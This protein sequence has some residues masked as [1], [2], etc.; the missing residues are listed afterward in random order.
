MQRLGFLKLLVAISARHST[1]TLPTIGQE[2]IR[3]LTSKVDLR[4]DHQLAKYV[5]SALSEQTNANLRRL[6]AEFLKGD[7]ERSARVT[8]EIQDAYLGLGELRS[9][10]G[11]LAPT[12]D[13][14]FPHWGVSLGLTRK[15]PF[16][17]LVRG[18]LLLSLVPASE[19][20][21]FD[22]YDPCC[23]PLELTRSQRLFFLFVIFERDL[24]VLVPLFERL[25]ERKGQFSDLEAGD[26]LPDVYLSAS[27]SLRR[28]GRGGVDADRALQL[29]ETAAAIRARHGKSYGKTVRE[30]TVTPRLEP[31]VDLGLLS[32]R[33]AF[34]YSYE[35]T[36]E[37]RDFFANMRDGWGD[38]FSG[39][40]KSAAALLG[41]DDQEVSSD[42]AL[43]HFLHSAWAELKSNLGYSP[44]SETL[45]LGLI[46]SLEQGAGW[47]EL[48]RARD[49]LLRTRREVRGLLRFNMDRRGTLSV[50]RF[51]RAP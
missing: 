37:G 25:L 5:R 16:G 15:E 41:Y 32:K 27:R 39:F 51:M 31:L 29:A 28:T 46:Y 10:R 6:A 42:S 23:N 21:A 13:S 8:I 2:L 33:E 17:A 40:G 38:Y 50:V 20:L 44:I 24:S 26:L 3:T 19:L 14:R 1:G 35:I 36:S 18:N 45:L 12:D 7:F 4:W 49:L 30:Q 48:G 22:Q 47:F 11:R 9:R 34:S 43:L